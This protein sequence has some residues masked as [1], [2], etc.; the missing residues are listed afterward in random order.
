MSDSNEI[1]NPERKLIEILI[2]VLSREL[3]EN[4]SNKKLG[5]LL[6]SANRFNRTIREKSKFRSISI[7]KIEER[8]KQIL[9]DRENLRIALNGLR[10][11]RKTRGYI[12][13]EDAK[14]WPELFLIKKLQTIFLKAKKELI[15]FS[16]L[17]KLFGS[18]HLFNE[19]L[20]S[21]CKFRI[22]T[23]NRI[24]QKLQDLLKEPFLTEALE[25]LHEYRIKRGFL[26][27]ITLQNQ[28]EI[29]LIRI[30]QDLYS[31]ELGY[32]ISLNELGKKF[33]S[34]LLF[35]DALR[36]ETKFVKLTLERMQNSIEKDLSKQNRLKALKAITSYMENTNFIDYDNSINQP[37]IELINYL[38]NIFTSH[39]S[40]L[41]S[42]NELTNILYP[43]NRNLLLSFSW[44]ILSL[45][46][47]TK[48]YF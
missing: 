27:N 1:F 35:N 20:T 22:I 38:R 23:I 4:I 7:D 46:T 19:V 28:E 16:N 30:L 31:K 5:I 10:S 6:L 3:G 34:R 40:T 26:K 2:E 43:V 29:E 25:A 36:K 39:N 17:G 9:K 48:T 8:V 33:G 12:N 47:N 42:I 24:E 37:E 18:K 15:P 45:L 21:N 44:S 11:Y 14:D 41:I 13:V 32:L